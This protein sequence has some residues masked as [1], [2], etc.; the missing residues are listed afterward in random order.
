MTN[1]A[2]RHFNDAVRADP[3]AARA[4]W[5]ELM[6][7]FAS[8]GITFGGMPMPTFLRPQFVDHR[9]LGRR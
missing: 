2:A 5:R 9:H 1:E 4:Q 8:R 6:D 3:A 7:S